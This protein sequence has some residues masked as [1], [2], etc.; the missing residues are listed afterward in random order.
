MNIQPD[1]L[2]F[3]SFTISTPTQFLFLWTEQTRSTFRYRYWRTIA[4]RQ[5]NVKAALA[6]GAVTNRELVTGTQ[7]LQVRQQERFQELMN[8]FNYGEIQAQLVQEARI[9]YTFT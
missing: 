3:L 9:Q 1:I 5:H 8:G 7:W 4:D 6:C 2:S